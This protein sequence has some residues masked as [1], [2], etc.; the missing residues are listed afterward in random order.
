MP[1]PDLNSSESLKC[2]ESLTFSATFASFQAQFAEFPWSAIILGPE[3]N[4]IGGGVLVGS[5]HV[6]TAAHKVASHE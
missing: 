2:S 5:H 4:Y 6:L 1:L 3:N